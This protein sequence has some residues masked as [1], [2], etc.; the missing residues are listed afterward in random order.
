MSETCAH[1][2]I[3]G[4]Y[5]GKRCQIRPMNGTYCN[6]HKKLATIDIP[7][8]EATKLTEHNHQMGEEC[9]IY[10]Y[11][12]G[13][14]N[15]TR[16][17]I[18]PIKGSYCHMHIK[19]A[20][21]EAD[22]GL[23][24]NEVKDKELRKKI[25]YYDQLR[26]RLF[27][28][29]TK[30]QNEYYEKPCLNFTE[31]LHKSGYG[32]IS[33]RGKPHF[34]HTTSY[35][36][37]HNIFIEDIPNINQ[38]GESLCICHGHGCNR[39]CIEP[40]HLTLDTLSHNNYED[41]IRDHTMS[42]GE[43]HPMSKITEDLARQIKHSKGEDTIVARS[44]R[45]G[46]PVST[47]VGIDY[48]YSW[49]FIPNKNGV[50]TDNST[51]RLGATQ[52]RRGNQKN[53]GTIMTPEIYAEALVTLRQKSI[54][55]EKVHPNVSTPCHLFQ[56]KLYQGYG[57]ISF[58]GISYKAHRLACEAK[59]GHTCDEKIVRHL[60]DTPSCCNPEHLEFGTRRQN[61]ID[62]SSYNKSYKL[63]ENQVKEIKT[64]FL[65]NT[66]LTRKEIAFKFGVSSRTIGR[67]YTGKIWSHVTL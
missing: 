35:A 26:D 15:G 61:A 11:I 16:C 20:K 19:Y 33:V 14:K 44:K 13:K 10:T 5:A 65:T 57:G 9:C 31:H 29:T 8:E 38:D 34:A 23:D 46:V 48:G 2:Y 60:C 56:G 27:S 1:T 37:S 67:I 25:K 55:S 42:R 32:L 47:T 41:K 51:R 64:L 22:K 49:A 3:R 40:S 62:A 28:K 52:R 66:S 63:T 30:V 36:V 4:Q 58:K 24:E 7:I 43:K 6:L 39:T 18:K 12:Q 50:I 53:K 59:Y 45:F 21:N 17:Q 54:D